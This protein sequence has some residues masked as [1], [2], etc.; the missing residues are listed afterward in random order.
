MRRL[1]LFFGLAHL[2]FGVYLLASWRRV[3]S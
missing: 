2:A 3:A 1:F